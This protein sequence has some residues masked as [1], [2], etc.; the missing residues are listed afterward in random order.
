M[1]VA[2]P[3]D[4]E[5]RAWLKRHVDNAS[6]LSVAV[7]HSTSWLH[8][9]MHGSGHATIDDLARLAGLLMG[10]NLPILTDV[11]RE[12]LKCCNGLEEPDLRDVI[13]FA[14]HRS[15]LSQRAQSKESNGPVARTPQATGRKARGRR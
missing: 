5:I 15:R 8:K 10:V 14:S 1:A 2:H 9:Y 12:L 7:G 4:G 6:E 11:Q 3:I 13:A